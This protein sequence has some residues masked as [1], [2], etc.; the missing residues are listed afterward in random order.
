MNPGP[1]AAKAESGNELADSALARSATHSRAFTTACRRLSSLAGRLFSGW[2]LRDKVVRPVIVNLL[3]AAIA[4]GWVWWY[5]AD[6]H[7]WL[8]PP[9]NVVN[10]PIYCALEPIVNAS[11]TA[12]LE[13]DLYI[14]NLEVQKHDQGT[15]R[16]RA[17][18]VPKDA[19]QR[20]PI[21]ITVQVKNGLRHQVVGIDS[22]ESFNQGK[23][24]LRASHEGDRQRWTV[25]VD[26]IESE[27]ILR[28]RIRTD[29]PRPITAKTD[30]DTVPFEVSYARGRVHGIE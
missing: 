21:T 3:T 22:D 23:G 7:R 20:P 26:H 14:I 30:V 8:F 13:A 17:D 18:A 12:L 9:P 15:L 24:R 2:E 25:S 5:S 29:A 6:I 28:A 16:A 11:P 10:W 4:A 27:A 1:P 19:G